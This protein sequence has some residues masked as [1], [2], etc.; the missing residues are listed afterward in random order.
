MLNNV[1]RITLTSIVLTFFVCY[2]FLYATESGSDHGPHDKLEYAKGLEENAKRNAQKEF[3]TLQTVN[4][5]VG[6]LA[7]GYSAKS[8]AIAKVSR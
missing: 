1:F 3:D 7:L 4:C 8:A 2:P 6:D 5:I